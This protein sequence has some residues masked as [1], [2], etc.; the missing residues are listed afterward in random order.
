[1]LAYHLKNILRKKNEWCENDITIIKKF[2]RNSII[3]S[4]PLIFIACF[5]IWSMILLRYSDNF[6]AF[7]FGII[8]IVFSFIFIYRDWKKDFKQIPIYF[9]SFSI[10]FDDKKFNIFLSNR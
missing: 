4:S 8:E 6:F 2:L 5:I 7:L 9:N 3:F 1:M 10:R